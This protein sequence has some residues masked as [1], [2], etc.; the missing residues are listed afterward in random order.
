MI[1]GTKVRVCSLIW[2]GAW[3]TLIRRPTISAAAIIG[4]ASMTVIRRALRPSSS[5][6]SS[7]IGDPPPPAPRCAART[8]TSST[9]PCAGEGGV[10]GSV[11]R[12]RVE[13]CASRSAAE[14]RHERPRDEVPAVRHYEQQ[15]L[16]REGDRGG[17]Q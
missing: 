17:R 4:A 9:S 3:K 10:V 8:S 15:D 12:R 16:E 7:F 1:F 5:A 11:Y 6:N 14:A 2:V 13:G